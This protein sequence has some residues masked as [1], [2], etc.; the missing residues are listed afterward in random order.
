MNA[1][2]A[3][4][5]DRAI[6]DLRELA[7]RTSTPGGAQRVCWT[8]EWRT[9]RSFLGEL[10]AEIGLEPGIDQAGNAWARLEGEDPDQP[11]LAVGS[12]V[13]SVPDG[14]W[15]DGAL[16]VMG[17]LAVVRGWA[18]SG[19]KPPRTLV[20]VDW[21]DEE[22]A[23]G[24]SLLGS[25]AATGT[26][27]PEELENA[28][29]R[30]GRPAREALAENGVELERMTD[31]QERLKGIGAYLELHI[32]Q[33]PVLESEGVKASAVTGCAGLERMR[34]SVSGAPS[35][36]G[37]TPMDARRDAGLVAAAL[38]LD[39]ERLAK[40]AGGVGTVGQLELEPGA[41]TVIPGA[42]SFSVDIRHRE[43]GPLAEMLAGVRKA[44]ASRSEER[45]CTFSEEPVWRIEPIPFDPK[46]VKL[47]REACAVVSGQDH[48]MP[49]GALHDAAEVA[50]RLPAAMLFCP[51][52]GG[53]SHSP[54]EDTAEGDLRL[55]V[56]TFGDLVARALG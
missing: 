53:V 27:R 25:A 39:V 56:S 49:S 20:F 19:R 16:G 50:K 9:A 10:L 37:T 23:F 17:A 42:A 21:A 36:A 45:S 55:A 38:A 29:A 44:V 52:I 2:P 46:L 54:A 18:Q 26:F 7:R 33:G 48:S 4:D 30:D 43:A 41:M 3:P 22:G 35:H 6:E 14:G 34:F 8:E 51:S 12:H 47:A 5:P 32:E 40:E 31:A 15:L 11:A 24:R 28:K 1:H 13:D